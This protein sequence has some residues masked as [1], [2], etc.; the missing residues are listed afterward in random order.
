M[1]EGD[2]I[3]GKYELERLIGLGSSGSVYAARHT[4]LNHKVALKFLREELRTDAE[5]VERFFRE[6]QAAA[7]IGSEHIASVTDMGQSD[8]GIPF[9]VMEYLEGQTLARAMREQSKLDIERAA[10]IATQLC[11]ALAA[12]HDKG[13]IHR[14]MKPDNVFLVPRADGSELA[15][16]LD[17]GIAKIHNPASEARALTVNGTTLGTPNYMAP[18]QAKALKDIDGRVDVYSVG[19]ILYEMVAGTQPITGSSFTD[20]IVKATQEDPEPPST[21]R[22]DL[23]PELEKIILKAMARDRT[24]RYQS[25]RELAEALE[26]FVDPTAAR[27][28]SASPA[29]SPSSAEVKTPVPVKGPPTAK[30]P[31]VDANAGAPERGKM[32]GLIIGGAV[33][34]VVLLIAAVIAGWFLYQR[35]VEEGAARS[36]SGA[37]AATAAPDSEGADGEPKPPGQNAAMPHKAPPP[38]HSPPVTPPMPPPVTP[39][40]TPLPGDLPVEDQ[41][42][43]PA[44]EAARV[45][46]DLLDN[47]DYLG[48]LRTLDSTTNTPPISRL[49]VLCLRGAGRLE[50]ACGAARECRRL[51]FCREYIR[52]NCRGV[53]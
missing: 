37:A 15:K 40:A 29:H 31:T 3:A 1:K 36:E 25:A 48:C 8:D 38:H 22:E 43:M 12:A 51:R 53:E 44:H 47:N 28:S 13:I 42:P 50:E 2:I 19:V 6:A 9:L 23:P 34:L 46:E 20:I 5:A 24:W 33:L 32:M 7:G 18:E 11:H 4:Q 39:P 52:G 16:V 26:A 49:R 45:A 35:G 10:T 17:F 30:M 41:P 21:H 27:L 14:D